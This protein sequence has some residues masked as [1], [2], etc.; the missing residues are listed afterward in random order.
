M[1]LLN[2]NWK[3]KYR[4]PR[5]RSRG[6]RLTKRRAPL[7][8]FPLERQNTA[9]RPLQLEVYL[10]KW[11]AMWFKM[12]SEGVEKYC[13]R[14]V[15]NEYT[16]EQVGFRWEQNWSF[17]SQQNLDVVERTTSITTTKT[18]T[19]KRTTMS[20]SGLISADL[21]QYKSTLKYNSNNNRYH[22]QHQEPYNFFQKHICYFNRS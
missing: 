22:Q 14:S 4:H 9:S 17:I 1:D 2:A 13:C 18:A 15:N 16:S 10:R 6:W 11:D 12:V 19:I 8:Q 5:Q 7:T 3:V 21:A 20:A